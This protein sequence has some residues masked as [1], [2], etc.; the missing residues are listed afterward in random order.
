[1]T[2]TAL[3]MGSCTGDFDEINTSKTGITVLSPA[4]LPF[5][6]ARAQQ[7]ASYAAGTYQT[8]QNLY[9]DLYAQYFATT[10]PNFQ[11]DRNFMHPT[12]INSHWN[13]IYTQV[14]PQLKSLFANTEASSPERALAD[15]W[16][17]FAFHR[18][19]DHYG[20][21]PYFDAGDPARTVKYDAQKDIYD[22]FF[23]RLAS[24]A[25]TLK[26]NA[27]AKPYASHDVMF[28]GD[29][30]KWLKF[31]NTLR[32]RLA[33]RIS[34]VDPARAKAEAEAA[35]AD[36]VMLTKEDNAT[37]LKNTTGGDYNGLATIAGWNE[38]RMSASMESY[39]KGYNDPRIGIF[40]QPAAQTGTYE[41][42]RNG[43]DGPL[44]TDPKH[45]NGATSNI[46][47]LW[48]SPNGAAWSYNYAKRQEIMLTAEAYFLRAEAA[49]NGWQAGG[50]AKDLYE[51]GIKASMAYWGVSD[52]EAAA[53]VTGTTTPVAPEDGLNSPAV[54]DIP[55]AWGATEAIQRQQIATQKWLAIYP[56]GQEAWAEL[57]RT[58][59]P[60]LYDL[61]VS[62][63]DELPVNA[64]PRRIPFLTA[65]YANNKPAMDNAVQLLGGPDKPTTRLWWDV[66]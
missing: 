55:V 52:A 38:F 46:G 42:L 13:P 45:N 33:L 12:W 22:D 61:A 10:T 54:A 8:A 17:V 32:L 6:F 15:I 5:L 41:G 62:V 28:D 53:Y 64:R 63:N 31:G 18:L 58:G 21:V 1:M 48:I 37:M 23:K 27:S 35:I 25:T 47:T 40:F 36:G 2:G 39:L 26:A 59:Y 11:T 19:T 4:E 60:K 9:S 20:P 43:L 49:L 66:E 34:K 51:S 3:F 24:A 56:D 16:W 30:A 65:E 50:T 14:V 57:R 44:L 29:A 7:Q